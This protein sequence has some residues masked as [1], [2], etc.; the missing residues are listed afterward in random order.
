MSQQRL[1]FENCQQR[2]LVLVVLKQI[3]L[4]V[5]DVWCFKPLLSQMGRFDWAEEFCQLVA[6]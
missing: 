4:K 5:Y 2:G 6:V 1:R 3:Y